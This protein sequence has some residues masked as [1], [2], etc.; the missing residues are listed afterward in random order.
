MGGGAKHVELI[1]VSGSIWGGGGI[2]RSM[3]IEYVA[4][5]TES[6]K[7]D[8]YLLTIGF[9]SRRNSVPRLLLSQRKF[10]NRKNCRMCLIDCIN[11]FTEQS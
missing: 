5:K 8:N 2:A 6:Y 10:Y 3:K 11:E 7:G 1:F 4:I 9:L